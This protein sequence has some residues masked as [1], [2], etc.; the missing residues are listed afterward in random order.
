MKARKKTDGQKP[1]ATAMLWP[2]DHAFLIYADS[3]LLP[4]AD[5]SGAYRA[6]RRLLPCSAKNSSLPLV[7]FGAFPPD[8]SVG[9]PAQLLR[10]QIAVSLI[11][12]LLEETWVCC[13]QVIKAGQY[14][15]AGAVGA[16][17]SG[18]LSVYRRLIAVAALADPPDLLVAASVD[19]RRLHHVVLIVPCFA[20]RGVGRH[21]IVK[22]GPN[23][24]PCT[25]G[26][27]RS[28]NTG[29][30]SLPVTVPLGTA[31][32]DFPGAAFGH[33]FRPE[34]VLPII[35]L[36]Q[37]LRVRHC[38]IGLTRNGLSSRAIGAARSA[39]DRADLRLPCVAPLAAPP[40]AAVAVGHQLLR[41]ELSVQILR[42]KWQDLRIHGRQICL[43]GDL[44]LSGTFHV[45]V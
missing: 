32:P 24:L 43:A 26:A 19:L 10:A 16:A 42:P 45:I 41:S 34:F 27:A 1:S 40:D 31:P 18:Y 35:P 14:L 23:P 21:Q 8:L 2:S 33:L 30:N 22:A 6:A 15:P 36:S 25:V 9:A 39:C 29:I 7:T 4:S 20:Q 3:M 38:N 5:F 17:V 12:P 37:E 11:I 44:P 13:C 28:R